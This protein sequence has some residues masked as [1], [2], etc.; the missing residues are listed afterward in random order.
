MSLERFSKEYCMKTLKFHKIY[1]IIAVGWWAKPKP[2]KT[3]EYTQNSLIVGNWRGRSY[4]QR[5]ESNTLCLKVKQF[6]Y[7]NIVFWNFE[8]KIN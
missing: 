5:C 2:D 7:R 6:E 3:Q 8:S 4:H 1:K